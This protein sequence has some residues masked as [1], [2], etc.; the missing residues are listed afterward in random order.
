MLK[1]QAISFKSD[2]PEKAECP[3]TFTVNILF[4]DH[5][6]MNYS[7]SFEALA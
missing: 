1:L 5:T 4:K 2:E 6:L 3:I 7:I